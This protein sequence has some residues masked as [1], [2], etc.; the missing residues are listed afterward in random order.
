MQTHTYTC[1]VLATH[2]DVDKENPGWTLFD[3]CP[4]GGQFITMMAQRAVISMKVELLLRNM[5][6]WFDMSRLLKLNKNLKTFGDGGR[7]NAKGLRL[8]CYCTPNILLECLECALLRVGKSKSA[9]RA[10]Q[11]ILKR[12][13]LTPTPIFMGIT[14]RQDNRLSRFTRDKFNLSV[15]S[16]TLR[17]PWLILIPVR[18]ILCIDN[19]AKWPEWLARAAFVF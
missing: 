1:V 5:G 7:E 14:R 10:L 12:A 15:L 6:P 13:V 9:C 8:F 11:F 3:S 16:C 2:R 19:G 17:F 18:P 4:L